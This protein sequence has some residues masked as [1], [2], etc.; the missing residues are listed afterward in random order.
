MRKRL[1]FMLVCIVSIFLVLGTAVAEKGPTAAEI[2]KQID[3]TYNAAKARNGGNSF[4]G[5]CGRYV[6]Y[7]LN[8]LGINYK[9]VAKAT[10]NGSQV[11]DE[12]IANAVTANGYT[13]VKYSGA[14]ALSDIVKANNG[15]PVYNIVV[16]QRV[17]NMSA[18]H[19]YFI[20]AIIN[21]TVY[22]SENST[23]GG[24]G[25][26]KIRKN[27]VA[28]MESNPQTNPSKKHYYSIIGAIHF[29]RNGAGAVDTG[30]TWTTLYY[31]RALYKGNGSK[32]AVKSKPYSGS[33]ADTLEIYTDKEFTIVSAVINQ[34]DNIWYGV[35]GGGYVNCNDVSYVKSLPTY[36]VT[37]EK[38]PSGSLTAGNP[39]YNKATISTSDSITKITSAIYKDDTPVQGPFEIACMSPTQ[40]SYTIDSSSPL[41]QNLTFGKL[42]AGYYTYR[43][44]VWHGQHGL[45]KEII[46]SGFTVGN[47]APKSVTLKVTIQVD[48]VGISDLSGFGAIDVYIDDQL[49]AENVTEYSGKHLSGNKYK[50][51]P[52]S[53]TSYLE[54]IEASSGS[55]TGTL[56]EKDTE[57]VLAFKRVSTPLKVSAIVDG[58]AVTSLQGIAAFDVYI[59][60]QLKASQ[61]SEYSVG[62]PAGYSYSVENIVPADGYQFVGYDSGETSGIIGTNDSNIKLMFSSES[63]YA[64]WTY[65]TRL[66]SNITSDEYEVQYQNIY[67]VDQTTSPGNDWINTGTVGNTYED[68]GSVYASLYPLSTSDTRV[69]KREEYFH[70]CSGSTGEQIHFTTNNTF[71]HVDFIYDVSSV[72]VAGT[73]TSDYDS[74]V[75]YYKL[76]WKSSGT[77]AYCGKEGMCSSSHA[78]R[79]CYWYHRYYYQDRVSVPLYRYQK[80][81]IWR[82]SKD[83]SASDYTVRYRTRIGEVCGITLSQEVYELKVGQKLPAS[84]VAYDVLNGV[85]KDPVFYWEMDDT[86]IAQYDGT[87]IIGISPG[88]AYLFCTVEAKYGDHVAYAAVV[89]GSD[90]DFIL[91]ANLRTI[92]A[93]AFVGLNAQTID[94]RKSKVTSIGSRAFADCTDLTV[95]FCPNT[96]IQIADDAFDG[97]KD[98]FLVCESFNTAAQYAYDHD[99]R[100]C[101]L[102]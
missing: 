3:T 41:A 52:T 63:E 5:W 76:K 57:I 22:W 95:V 24:I 54:F 2:A 96:L 35:E 40:T 67:S 73:Y 51:V 62:W 82:S 100:Y 13:Q 45:S 55:L 98:L 12:M 18:G 4:S 93:E 68:S 36:K 14:H 1:F 34:Y 89:V 79:S 28:Q 44:T 59:Q 66:P 27:T 81:D 33:K 23:W 43:V 75:K 102:N 32:A 38:S 17:T 84:V 80:K 11:Y 9:M 64:E 46:N 30:A 72:T 15:E 61:V 8:I 87:N 50:I 53:D 85:A 39:F 20:H 42:T 74:N 25:E 19:T 77:W 92:E 48:G 7:Q 86:S 83:S 78:K 26:G 69:F 65:A 37:N 88:V 31:E 16:S 99:L 49:I 90:T 60:D 47:P 91:P 94:L 6:S 97:C 21:N 58:T 10:F 56:G 71:V 70:V 101:V 29:T